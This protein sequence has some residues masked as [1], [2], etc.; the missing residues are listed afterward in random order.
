V[1]GQQDD[2][3]FTGRKKMSVESDKEGIRNQQAMLALITYYPMAAVLL[4]P[5]RFDRMAQELSYAIQNTNSRDMAELLDH[6]GNDA[7]SALVR[8]VSGLWTLAERVAA[9]MAREI[10]DAARAY[11]DDRLTTHLGGRIGTGTGITAEAMSNGAK[12]L[13]TLVTDLMTNPKEVAPKLLVLVLSSVVASGGIDGNGGLPDSD[14]PLMGIGAHRSPFTHSI[15]IGSAL[16]A[17]ILLLTR[18]VLCTH[19]NL[20]TGHDP[21]WNGIA[22]SAVE[23]LRSAGKGASIGIAYH[24]MVDAVVQ[25]GAYHGM[26]FDMPIEA[27]QA[28]F[29]ANSAAEAT[30]APSFPDEVALA[31]STPAVVATHKKFRAIRMTLPDPV[32]ES[33]SPGV[34]AI[35]E[36]YG[37]WMQAL[38]KRSIPPTTLEQIQ[39]IRVADGRC[40]P[41]SPHESAWRAFQDAKVL[42]GLTTRP[43]V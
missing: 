42:A 11:S 23:I 35:L 21:L 15:I 19:K 33:L 40:A 6:L 20:P 4:Q 25:P 10:A 22:R 32:K 24:L 17:A 29:A 7:G 18:I 5:S 1:R 9:G 30:A 8:R 2:I 41:G 3:R 43:F 12:S 37:A 26:P 39:F 27:H 34:I 14:I 31:N 38:I 16:E 28:I 13:T 36:K